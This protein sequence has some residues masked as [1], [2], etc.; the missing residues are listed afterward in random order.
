MAI[1]RVHIVGVKTNRVVQV[2]PVTVIIVNAPTSTKDFED[3]AWET[4]ID[5]KDVLTD[6]NRADYQFVINEVTGF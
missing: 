2:K 6:A 3:L 5:D 1:R 4:A